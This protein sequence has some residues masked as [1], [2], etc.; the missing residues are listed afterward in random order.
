[1]KP[2][3]Q[4]ATLLDL[5]A[6]KTFTD[7]WLAGRGMRVNTPGAVN[8]YFISP[9]QHK[10]YITRYQTFIIILDQKLIAWCVIQNDGSMIHLL[11][12]G[13][14][15]GQGLGTL[16]LH[17]LNPHRV[18]SKSNQ[19]SGDPAGFYEHNGYQL[20]DRVQSRSR[21]DIDRIRPNRK[22]VID[23]YEKEI[24]HVA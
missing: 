19:S 17:K 3:I 11:V 7:F 20:V 13:S 24:S 15:R 9:S 23:I 10:K 5:P 8:D 18:H 2:T 21:L 14:H 4:K 12:A 6:I 22:K 16:I 1:M